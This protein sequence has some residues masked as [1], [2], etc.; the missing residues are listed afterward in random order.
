MIAE[1]HM[2]ELTGKIKVTGYPKTV[3]IKFISLYGIYGMS[4]E[5][6]YR[7]PDIIFKFHKKI[8]KNRS[9]YICDHIE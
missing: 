6:F 8:N 2:G 9:Y 7:N 5:Y 3:S 1:L 4:K